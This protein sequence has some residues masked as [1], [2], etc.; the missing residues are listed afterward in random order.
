M[1]MAP[2][3]PR[4]RG[5]WM[6]TLQTPRPHRTRVHRSFAIRRGHERLCSSDRTGD[7]ICGPRVAGHMANARPPRQLRLPGP[8]RPKPARQARACLR[9]LQVDAPAIYCAVPRS[10]DRGCPSL[11][12][13]FLQLKPGPVCV[14][15]RSGKG[16]VA[17]RTANAAASVLPQ[18]SA[19]VSARLGV[20]APSR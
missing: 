3:A 1:C 17:T 16:R 19:C 18:R 11:R 2:W 5:Y 7:A 20:S 15:D 12:E 8:D 9:C 14:A 10:G 4:L 6:G 13:D